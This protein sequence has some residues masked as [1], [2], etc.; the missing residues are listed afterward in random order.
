AL[1]EILQMLRREAQ[2]L[3][4]RA[5]F[6]LMRCFKS[7][8]SF[9]H[10]L[11]VSAASLIARWIAVLMRSRSR[12]SRIRSSHIRTKRSRTTVGVTTVGPSHTACR[13]ERADLRSPEV[14]YGGD[15]RNSG[16]T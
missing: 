10:G 6:V 11:W 14:C 13:T 8:R 5:K 9:I 16:T 1:V 2:R 4:L 15:T 12:G 7:R 3:N